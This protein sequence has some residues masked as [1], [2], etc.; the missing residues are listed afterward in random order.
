MLI[1]QLQI[2]PVELEV[3]ANVGTLR[4]RPTLTCRAKTQSLHLEILAQMRV[5]GEEDLIEHGIV[6][7]V[8]KGSRAKQVGHLPP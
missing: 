3:S 1:P 6:H 2:L 5:P 7:D 8:R 4:L